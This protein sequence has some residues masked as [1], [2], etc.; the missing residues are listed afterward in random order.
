MPRLSLLLLPLVL[1]L[2][3]CNPANQAALNGDGSAANGGL[4]TQE[5]SSYGAQPAV[6]PGGLTAS[7]SG[8]DGPVQPGSQRD[9]QR[10]ASD[11]I[12][13]DTDSTRINQQGYA[14]LTQVAQW[15][16]SN[17]QVR[18][19]IE[20]HAD[21][22]GTREYNFALGDQRATAVTQTLISLG[23]APSRLSAVSYGK[24]RP[25]VAISQPGAWSANRRAVLLV[26]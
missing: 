26:M 13:F 21:E 1:I 5:L 9:L 17:P 24:E 23:V 20:G 19:L 15:M 3:A 10:F 8:F 6:M 2:A 7:A 22:R 18:L 25:E 14:L 16:R 4:P 12:L 11:R